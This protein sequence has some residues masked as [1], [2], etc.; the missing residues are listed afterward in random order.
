M[1]GRAFPAL[2]LL[3]VPAISLA[4][5]LC[6]AG[7]VTAMVA[8]MRQ[9]AGCSDDARADRTCLRAVAYDNGWGVFHVVLD[10]P[11]AAPELAGMSRM[12]PTTRRQRAVEAAVGA[13]RWYGL[14]SGA[15]GLLQETALPGA[16]CDAAATRER[17]RSL[18]VLDARV[19]VG[20]ELWQ[21]TVY[22][23]GTTRGPRAAP[24]S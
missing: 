22:P 4:A 12:G 23:D 20:R 9:A 5:D 21:V 15:R 11:A 8:Q 1:N 10:V 3:A 24:G 6:S 16:A 14:L 13:A 18:T 19:P 7:D 2:L 17:I